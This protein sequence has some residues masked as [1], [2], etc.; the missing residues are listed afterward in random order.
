MLKL[1]L[2][3][4]GAL[5]GYGRFAVVIAAESEETARKIA[6]GNDSERFAELW[7]KKVIEYITILTD[8]T[9]QETN[10]AKCKEIGTANAD[11]TTGIVL[12]LES[13]PPPSELITQNRG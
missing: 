5:S 10:G 12:S 8:C 3:E 1:F 6:A 11:T 9:L 13:F 7:L 4:R 2:L